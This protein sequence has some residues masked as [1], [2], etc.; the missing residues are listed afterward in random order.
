MRTSSGFTMIEVLVALSLF[1]IVSAG[2][3][4]ALIHHTRSNTN[5]VIRTGAIAALQHGMD[6]LRRMDPSAMPTTG[7]NPSYP[8]VVG[9]RTYQV[10]E[11]FCTDPA[12]CIDADTR[13]IRIEVTH[14][15]K[16]YYAAES[17]FT[18]LR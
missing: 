1:A 14:L 2:I 5:S 7:A 3:T 16:L 12:L 15:A 13:Q 17:V 8:L 10:T 6:N 4:P 18:R 9:G 11:R